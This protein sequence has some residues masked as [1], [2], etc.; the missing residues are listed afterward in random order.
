MHNV[1]KTLF[2]RADCSGPVTKAREVKEIVQCAECDGF[3]GKS[4]NRQRKKTLG[5]FVCPHW[6]DNW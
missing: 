1:H 2:K 5:L 6:S 4:L 3:Q